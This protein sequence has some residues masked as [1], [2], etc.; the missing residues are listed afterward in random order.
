MVCEGCGSV[1]PD[2]VKFCPEC[3]TPA[4]R[5]A[6]ATCGTPSLGGRFCS[7]CGAPFGAGVPASLVPSAATTFPVAERR[8]TSVLFGDLVGFTPL[9]EGMDSEEVRELLSAYFQQCRVVVARYGGT[10]EKFIGDAVM[11]VWGVPTAHEDD[12]ERAVRA[13]LELV[14]MVTA[15][16]A[17][18]GAPRLA[19]RVGI[20][21]GEV[22]VTVGATAEGMV[23]GDAVN[24][25]ARVQSAATAGQVWV[26]DT[27]RG[28]ASA[29]ITFS[30]TGE[31]ALKGKAEPMRL[32]QAGVVVAEVGG[33]QRVDGLEAA[34]TGRDA[35]LRLVKELFHAT[36][37]S[38]RPRLVILDGEAGVG[39][40]RLAWEF[41]KYVD[42]LTATVAWHRSRCLSYGDGVAF[43]AL[44]EAVRTRFGL[45]EADADEAVSERL[46]VGLAEYVADEREREWLRPR[47]AVLLGEAGG[48]SFPREDLFAAWTA[49]LEHLGDDGSAVVLVLDD[50]QHA[51][52]AL[53]D[54]L[55]HLVATARTSIF[56]LALARPELLARRPALGGRRASVV[57]LEPLTDDAMTAL[58]DGLV[59]D[60]PAQ[61][62]AALVER[63]E[64]I[65][66]F[67]V[68]TVRA[69]IDRDLVVP[70][71]GRYVTADASVL[72]LDAIG[73][74]ATLQALVAARLDSLTVE[75]RRVVAD[76]AVLGL[77]FT[78]GG[79]L[80]LGSTPETL[81]AALDSLRRREI[82]TVDSDRFSSERGQHRFV[83]S[84]L[85]QVAYATQSR[86]D[87]K[88]RHLAA[89]DYLAA[90]PDP[91]DDL[92]ALIAQHLLDAVDSAPDTDRPDLLGR[93]ARYLERAATRAMA[94][95]APADAVRLLQDA[96]TCTQDPADLARLHLAAAPVAGTAGDHGAA[97]EHA[98]AAT[99]LYD[100]L[101]S[102]VDAATAAAAHAWSLRSLGD[103]AA[104]I[105][106]AEPRWHALEGRTDSDPAL[107]ALARVL[108]AAHLGLGDL[109]AS[110]FYTERRLLLAEGQN[111]S[112]ALIASLGNI[113]SRFQILGAPTA[114][115]VNLQAAADLARDHGQLND[116]ATILCNRASML[117]S[118]D[119]P[120]AV[121]D[122]REAHDVARRTGH[123]GNK[124]FALANLAIALWHSGDLPAVGSVLDDALDTAI[125]T[126]AR[127]VLRTIEVWLADATGRPI[128]Q[129]DDDD[130][131]TGTDDEA[132]RAWQDGTDLSRALA[133][134]DT[135]RVTGIAGESLPRLLA[136][137]GLE[138]DFCV[139]WPPLVL[140]ALAAGDHD[141]AALLLDPVETARPGRLSPAVAA[142]WHRLRGLVAAAGGDDPAFVETELLTGITALDTFG[143][144]G[145]RARAQDELARWLLQQQRP[146]DAAPLLEAARTTYTEI[147]ATGWLARLDDW[148]TSR[149][150]T[151]TR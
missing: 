9:S 11:A 120:A 48:G 70:R 5:T 98:V 33:G 82:L 138:D 103:N 3:G 2:G 96:L 34:F 123:Q 49:F 78:R 65:P 19:Q 110:G 81:D 140:A 126:G 134:G 150:P 117:N 114:A 142:Q 90:E 105:E 54:F 92:A 91:A 73:A 21:T 76:A 16:G 102:E 133:T 51:D 89:A 39:K 12:A 87:R 58:V 74:P 75:E 144:V 59:A 145:Y 26:D 60:L 143:A 6:C 129:A 115:L 28:L 17:D 69:L 136:S 22:A 101:G 24:T 30:D 8:V 99:A 4:P 63:A 97:R 41:E 72:D 116:L 127:A 38:A 131:D 7:E 107:L 14:A 148:D 10:V 29:A 57:R 18:V 25:A 50:V 135:D 86:R 94:I 56:V 67:A 23:A 20:V 111:D 85:R 68:E 43:W 62:R 37:E 112:S 15:L 45:V 88:A 66:L 124:D 36:E 79:L 40:S 31:H 52:D 121:A 27:T 137:G 151:R 132:A 44:A 109:T 32:W 146:V 71:D 80:A 83:Q 100:E 125:D 106:V 55:D 119:L 139:L 42:G 95:G 118:R 130:H 93:A 77:S 147:G 108:A 1:L 104:A 113:G 64:G 128:P 141:L 46:D 122:A 61:T 13:G 47:L 35:D 84:V 53:L 149:H